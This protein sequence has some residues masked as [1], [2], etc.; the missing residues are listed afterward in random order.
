MAQHDD[1]K[2]ALLELDEIE[3]VQKE[4]KK[5]A[6]IDYYTPNAAQLRCHQSKAK[7]I[8]YCGGNRAG[9]TTLGAV[10]LAFHLTRK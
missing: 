9:K 8:L 10:E 5:A 6:G 7:I 2:E 1:L 3:R 4:R